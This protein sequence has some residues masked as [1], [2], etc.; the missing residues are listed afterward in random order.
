[1]AKHEHS[2]LQKGNKCIPSSKRIDITLLFSELTEWERNM[3]VVELYYVTDEE[4]NSEGKYDDELRKQEEQ[5]KKRTDN[6]PQLAR[7]KWLD[8][9]IEVVKQDIISDLKKNVH[10]NLTKDDE[11]A[12]QNL[13]QDDS[14]VIRPT[15]K[16]SGIVM[17]DYKDYD[18]TIKEEL[19]NSKTYLKTVKDQLPTTFIATSRLILEHQQ[20]V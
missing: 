10:M 12:L 11:R 6:M 8:I 20:K 15:D 3:R 4:D 9:Y 16:G 1:M 18:K 5:K 19:T 7:E 13:M 14:I 2:L 17:M